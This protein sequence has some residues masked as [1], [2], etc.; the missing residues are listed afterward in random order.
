MKLFSLMLV[1][2]FASNCNATEKMMELNGSTMGTTYHIKIVDA[3]VNDQKGQQLQAVIDTLLVVL[4]EQ[5]STY[6]P[7]SEI[8]KFNQA[9]KNTYNPVSMAFMEVAILA[10]QITKESGGA[11]D[12]TVMPAVNLWGFGRTARR[13]N[14]PT[15]AEV[16]EVKKY[17]GMKNISIG[18]GT[19]MKDHD[20]TE[21][22]FSAIAKGFGVDLIAGALAEK[23][24]KNYMVEIGGE[25]VVRGL[26]PHMQNGI[27]ALI[28]HLLNIIQIKDFKRL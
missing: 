17:V 23:G 6:I 12:A 11:F 24:Y 4:N 25:V 19:V 15:D 13:E 10:A 3:S 5:M 20:K 28:G 9:K 2:V 22:D 21:L 18:D 27:L 14:P 16:A 7:S 8:S 26:N 1:L